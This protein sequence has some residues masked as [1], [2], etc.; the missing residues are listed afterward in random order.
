MIS[1]LPWGCAFEKPQNHGE[2]DARGKGWVWDRWGSMVSPGAALAPYMVSVGNHE[3]D[4]V[5][6][7]DPSG[8]EPF[9]P[10]WWNNGR[11]ASSGECGVP[12]YVRWGSAVPENKQGKQKVLCLVLTI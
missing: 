3:L 1:Y 11:H 9:N 7:D 6:G 2:H 5:A 4:H 12:T 8:E 10:I